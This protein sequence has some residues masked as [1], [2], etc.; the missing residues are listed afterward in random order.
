MKVR[1][2][3]TF[4]GE[5]NE[6][7]ELY[8]QAFLTDT[9]D[10]MRFSD[11]PPNPNWTIPEPYLNRVVQAML[12]LGD[13]FIRLSDSGPN[14]SLNAPESERVSIAV[15]P[16]VQMTEHAFGVLAREGRVTMALEPTFY[17]QLAGVVCDKYGVVWNFSS[18]KGG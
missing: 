14:Q 8:K 6:A 17:S 10:L 12:R 11:L 15:E 2:Y 3:L 5:C 16:N 7:I 1:P 13:D 18:V 9:I 4:D